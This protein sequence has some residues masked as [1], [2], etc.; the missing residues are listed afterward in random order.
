MERE[1]FV[2]AFEA[3]SRYANE[4]FCGKCD[5]CLTSRE[6]KALNFDEWYKSNVPQPERKTTEEK[7]LLLFNKYRLSQ[8]WPNT[9]MPV[10]TRS[11]FIEAMHEYAAQGLS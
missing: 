1:L 9:N 6:P 7:I 2:K 10:M 5:Y 3:G 4:C 8:N 11:G